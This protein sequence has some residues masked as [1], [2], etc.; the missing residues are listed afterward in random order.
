M[1]AA[2]VAVFAAAAYLCAALL[3]LAWAF[4]HDHEVTEALAP[5][6][7]DVMAVA[8]AVQDAPTAAEIERLDLILWELEAEPGH[9]DW[10]KLAPRKD[11]G[12]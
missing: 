6:D 11:G 1:T 3:L 5:L 4:R 2:E 9:W 10:D 12:R 8:D 7:D